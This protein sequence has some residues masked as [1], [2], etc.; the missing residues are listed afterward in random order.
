MAIEFNP[1]PLIWGK[2]SEQAQTS[3]DSNVLPCARKAMLLNIYKYTI[4]QNYVMKI[5]ARSMA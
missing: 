3:F 5:E 2:A 1:S 4:Y